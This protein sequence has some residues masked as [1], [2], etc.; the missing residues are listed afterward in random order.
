VPQGARL[1]RVAANSNDLHTAERQLERLRKPEAHGLRRR[2]ERVVHRWLGAQRG[3]DSARLAA[4]GGSCG[5]SLAIDF[6]VRHAT[7]VKGI[8]I[9]SGP[10]DSAQRAFVARTPSVGVLGAASVEEGAS[11]GYIEPV[12]KASPNKVSRMVVLHGAGH[13]TEILKGSAEFAATALDW[14]GTQLALT[15][16]E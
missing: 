6:A 1:H 5:V 13:G 2:Y 14:L 16:G 7:Q 15:R 8:V 12:V 10:S 4:V 9:L 11:V 3:V